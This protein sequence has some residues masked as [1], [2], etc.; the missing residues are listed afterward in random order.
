[1]FIY[2]AVAAEAPVIVA[3]QA[4]L[5]S[6]AGTPRPSAMPGGLMGAGKR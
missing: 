2:A 5:Q 6:W 4:R 3:G 1:M